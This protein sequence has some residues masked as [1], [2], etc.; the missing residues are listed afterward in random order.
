GG[1]RKAN[2]A[3]MGGYKD[4]L[5]IARAET[6]L[7]DFGNDSFLEGLEVL[8]RALDREAHLNARGQQVLPGR[9]V[10]HLKQRLMIEDCYR[11]HPEIEDVPLK[12]PLIGISLPRTGST[13]LSFLLAEDPNIR[14]LRAF[15]SGEPCPPPAT[16]KRADPRIKYDPSADRPAGSHLPNS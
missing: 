3:A 4:F 16:V 11:R 1:S 2:E 8:T 7:H 9:I 13:V 15:E 14:Y 10:H 6:G 12:A 5:D